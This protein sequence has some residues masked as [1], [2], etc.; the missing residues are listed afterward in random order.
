[1]SYSECRAGILLFFR[2]ILTQNVSVTVYS[3]VTITFSYLYF[4]LCQVVT[5]SDIFH[6]EH[7]HGF[8]WTSCLLKS[9]PLP[10]T[11]SWQIEQCRG[12]CLA[13]GKR[14]AQKHF[15]SFPRLLKITICRLSNILISHHFH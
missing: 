9:Y 3:P 10:I 8:Y 6:S 2:C 7:L 11:G 13:L 12:Y 14:D 5:C 15:L 4:P 1:M